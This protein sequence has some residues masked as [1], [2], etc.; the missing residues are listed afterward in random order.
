MTGLRAWYYRGD[1][2]GVKRLPYLVRW[3]ARDEWKPAME[4]IWRTFMKYEAKD[5]TEEGVQHFFDFITDEDLYASFL[6]GEYRLMV[7]LDK[8]CVIG[9]GSIRDRNV[10]S[11]LFVEEAYHHRGV[12][13]AILERLC[14]YLKTEEGERAMS[15]QAAP[16]A[17][18]F[19]RRQGFQAVGPEMQF[20]GIRVTLMEKKF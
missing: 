5:F 10:L 4:M 9:A 14:E 1:G 13:S 20:S 15:L 8:G 16:Y 12:G 2:L 3:A 18:G 11:L 17:V 19:Y 6:K 7:A